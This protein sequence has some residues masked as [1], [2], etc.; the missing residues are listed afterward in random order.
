MNGKTK[1]IIKWTVI[2]AIAV[3]LSITATVLM[4]V[5]CDSGNNQ[6]VNESKQ[7]VAIDGDGNEIKDGQAMPLTMSFV[8]TS[9]ASSTASVSISASITPA[10]AM[11]SNPTWTVAWKDNTVTKNVSEYV[12][13]TPNN[14]TATITC[15]K[16]FTDK[17]ELKF[18]VKDYYDQEYAKTCELNY[19]DRVIGIESFTARYLPGNDYAMTRS[20][21][22]YNTYR[23]TD[24]CELDA[25]YYGSSSSVKYE[26][27][28]I[29]LKRSGGT[30]SEEEQTVSFSALRL[31]YSVSYNGGW[32]SKV[33]EFDNVDITPYIDFCEIIES[34]PE[35]TSILSASN[36]RPLV[37]LRFTFT[38]WTTAN[39]SFY[40]DCRLN[41]NV[42]IGRVALSVDEH[43][44]G[45]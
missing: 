34:L 3:I 41:Y 4:F 15:N 21:L 28:Q 10:D 11:Y 18:T 19:L 35:K 2:L 25:F 9:A 31:Q 26:L 44:F 20:P 43:T 17:I 29:N 36:K 32:V 14:L 27:G 33:K 40:M 42:G 22:P 16:V 38:N 39:N 37:R 1:L 24:P 8:R 30:I 13:V 12:T 6:T 5:Y 7:T 45:R 23:N